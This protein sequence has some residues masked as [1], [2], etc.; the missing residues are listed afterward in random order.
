[1]RVIK[2]RFIKGNRVLGT[3]ELK[4]NG[5]IDTAYDWDECNQFTGLLDRNGK[6]IWEGDIVDYFYE[7]WNTGGMGERRKGEVK[8]YSRNACFT[9]YKDMVVIGNIYENPELLKGGHDE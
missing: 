8:W 3:Q 4:P 1:M 2:F 6:E 5:I 7:F 9:L